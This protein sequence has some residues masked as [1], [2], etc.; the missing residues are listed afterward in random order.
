MQET[1]LHKEDQHNFGQRDPYRPHQPFFKQQGEHK[2]RASQPKDP[3][4]NSRLRAGRHDLSH[5]KIRP[6]RPL[7]LLLK[8]IKEK[9]GRAERLNYFIVR[10]RP[11]R[12]AILA[13]IQGR[14][15]SLHPFLP[16]SFLIFAFLP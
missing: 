1:R 8:D 6:I 11:R 12:L 7:R 3:E 13:R 2:E 9:M 16:E 4:K 5:R 10:P 14:D 15:H